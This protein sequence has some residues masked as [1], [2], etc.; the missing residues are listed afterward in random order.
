MFFSSIYKRYISPD[1]DYIVLLKNLLGFMPGNINLYRMA[2]RHRS[3]AVGLKNGTKSS[4]ER[5]E[6]L[7]DAVLGCIIA[8]ELFKLYPYKDEGFL[9]QMRSKIVSRE[10]L[11]E[12]SKR[13]GLDELMEFDAPMLHYENKRSSL[14]GDAFEALVG[15]IYLDKDYNFTRKFIIKSIIQPH[16]D[17]YKLEFTETNFK[18]KLLEWCQRHGK[19]VRFELIPNEEGE[20][21]KLF[22]IQVFIDDEAYSIG[23][24]YTKKRA[25]QIASE[26]TCELIGA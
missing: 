3:A 8:E 26:K 10:S 5:L 14:L 16:I 18:S 22:T 11:N 2:F 24:D 7:G 17:I 12:L 9:T 1:R 25:E 13:I 20:S 19:K 23:R 15:A 4:N 21:D 6:F